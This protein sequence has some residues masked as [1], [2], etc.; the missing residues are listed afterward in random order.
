M[1]RIIFG[2]VLL[3]STSVHAMA[4]HPAS[5]LVQATLVRGQRVTRLKTETAKVRPLC[6][7]IKQNVNTNHIAAVWLGQYAGLAS[8]KAGARAFLNLISSIVVTRAM[9]SLGG[10]GGGRF[11]VDPNPTERAKGVFAV[12]VTV[13]NS[14]GNPYS[15]RVIVARTGGKYRIIDGEYLVFSAVNYTA[16][17]FQKRL[18]RASATNPSH[19]ISAMV[20]DLMA[21]DGFISCL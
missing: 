4:M 11:V 2:L 18:D 16:R 20:H 1:N 12:G 15:G 13:Y 8:D 21:E 17:D 14:A 19:P 10:A 5:Q 6:A 7:L 3:A 9:P